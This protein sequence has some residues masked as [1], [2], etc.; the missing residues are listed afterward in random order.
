MPGSTLKSKVITV[1]GEVDPD[2]LGTV[3]S[4][5][6]VLADMTAYFVEPQ[7]A[8]DRRMAHAPVC[9]EIMYWVHTHLMG[10][11]DDLLMND[12]TL[13]IQELLRFK[14]AGGDTVVELSCIGLGRDP[15]G[16]QR[17]S[18]A[19]GLHIIM[20]A[21]YYVSCSHPEELKEK[22][23]REIADE[24]TRDIT[25]GVGNTGVRAGIIGEVGCSMP[26][27]DSE[28]KVLRASAIAQQMTGAAIN[29]HPSR[30]DELLVESVDILESSG[31]DLSR[32][33]ISHAG[34]F[35]F[36]R[37]TIKGLAGRG[38]CIEFDTFGH[39]AL[40][41]EC[42]THESKLLEMP[43]EVQRIYHIREL[44]SE[45]FLDRILISQ[46][47]C[48]KHKYVKYGG[49]G[50]AH[51]LEHIVPWMKQR[52]IREEQLHTIVVENPKRI[53]TLN[54]PKL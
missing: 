52:D 40:P 15:L 21:G 28:R 48:F 32:V 9:P 8:T 44:I 16:L 39:P 13:A 23:E 41:I 45:G 1:L 24:I 46:D 10:N 27:D 49:Y 47:C 25:I 42:F 34:H 26:L 38:C 3:L 29:M 19:T 51:I 35:P 53:L 43:S 17:I 7:A 18:R 36:S 4:H 6:H 12:E 54:E 20:G 33:V 5:E 2:S 30:S 37:N 31:A 50:Y 22:N 14:N 11:R